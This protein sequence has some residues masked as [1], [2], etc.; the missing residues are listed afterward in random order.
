MIANK[1]KT[2]SDESNVVGFSTEQIGVEIIHFPWYFV[3]FI[4]G[5]FLQNIKKQESI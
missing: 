1:Q 5:E 3:C 2:D 4:T